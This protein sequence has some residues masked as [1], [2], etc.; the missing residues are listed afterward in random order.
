[1]WALWEAARVGSVQPLHQGMSSNRRG[2]AA[3]AALAAACAR[4]VRM[5]PAAS[6]LGAV[7]AAAAGMVSFGL[8]PPHQTFGV[9][10]VSLYVHVR[11]FLMI[12]CV[13]LGSLGSNGPSCNL[14]ASGNHSR[15][16]CHPHRL[17]GGL[18]AVAIALGGGG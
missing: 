15:R 9:Q 16:L 1:M 12:L 6:R 10:T 4:L 2:M 14:L 8:P 3:C 5:L 17:Y 7:H 18:P 13:L 11:P